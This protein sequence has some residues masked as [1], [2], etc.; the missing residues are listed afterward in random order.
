ME[1]RGTTHLRNALYQ[2]Y[3]STAFSSNSSNGFLRTHIYGQNL[4]TIKIDDRWIMPLARDFKGFMQQVESDLINP[5]VDDSNL[6]RYVM[7]LVPAQN[8][9]NWNCTVK[10]TADP[11]MGFLLLG[12][13]YGTETI[14]TAKTP[15]G[16]V[17]YGGGGCV[18][19][20]D[21]IPLI[22]FAMEMKYPDGKA[23]KLNPVTIINPVV[24]QREDLLSKYIVKKVIPF[25]SDYG[26]P[27]GWRD[28]SWYKDINMKT[29]ISHEITK[30]I[31]TPAKPVGF[32]DNELW[33]CAEANLNEM[34]L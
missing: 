22:V 18:F 10:R 3:R 17:Y 20:K 7:P 4:V 34:L 9:S 19:D 29:V 8:H 14:R 11:L 2:L 23:T 15:I 5:F 33:K 13:M 21:L 28:E 31:E 24:F 32:L 30:F 1:V 6:G 12:R 25:L 27:R 26:T 16:E